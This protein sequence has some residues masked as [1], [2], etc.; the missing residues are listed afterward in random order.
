MIAPSVSPLAE[1]RFSPPVCGLRMV[2]MDTVTLMRAFLGLV[3]RV[4]LDDIERFFGDGAVDDAVAA[5]LVTVRI[6]GGYQ[7]VVR[8]RLG[9]QAHVGAAR[10]RLGRGVWV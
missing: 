4:L 2:G 8:V 6:A 3:R 10:G 7:Y 5:Q 1:T 9:G